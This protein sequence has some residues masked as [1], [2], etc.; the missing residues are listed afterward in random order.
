VHIGLFKHTLSPFHSLCLF[1]SFSIIFLPL[2]PSISSP[3]SS[4]TCPPQSRL[5][6]SPDWREV[7]SRRSE[8][9][10]DSRSCTSLRSPDQCPRQPSS[11][12]TFRLSLPPSLR[13]ILRL[14]TQHFTSHC[15]SIIPV[16]TILPNQ[17][18]VP[19]SKGLKLLTEA[20][21]LIL[22]PPLASRA[23]PHSKPSRLEWDQD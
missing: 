8:Q 10:M 5:P 12:H 3:F 19:M 1:L 14:L 20:T 13:L 4:G 7:V 22:M 21:S 17:I 11:Q 6:R 2:P 18:Q 15:R 23:R 16:T 9:M